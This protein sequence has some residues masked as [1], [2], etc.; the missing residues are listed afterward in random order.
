MSISK[1]TTSRLQKNTT[2]T[3]T[4]CLISSGCRLISTVRCCFKA[5]SFTTEAK[6]LQQVMARTNSGAK[7]QVAWLRWR[8]WAQNG[9]KT[10]I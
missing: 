2:E 10:Y 1:T 4:S 9:S 7:D 3:T 6:A 5:N 8:K